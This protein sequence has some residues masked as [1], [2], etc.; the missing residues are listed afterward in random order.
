MNKYTKYNAETGVIEY[1]FTGTDQDALVNT[2]NILGSYS[3][4]EYTIVDNQP[5]RKAQSDIDQAETDRAWTILRNRRN[6]YLTDSDWTQALD[7]PLSDSKKTEWA[8]YRQNLRDLPGTVS[9]PSNVSFP[10]KPD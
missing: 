4:D 10:D 6:G 5:V 8:T 1:V 2:P 7:S 9:D 3:S